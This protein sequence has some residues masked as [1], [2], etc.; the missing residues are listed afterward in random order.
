MHLFQG[1]KVALDH[2]QKSRNKFDVFMHISSA[3]LPFYHLQSKVGSFPLKPTYPV[4]AVF[5]SVS[6]TVILTVLS[7]SFHLLTDDGAYYC[8]RSVR[9]SRCS[10][11]WF[12]EE[13]N[14]L[15][16]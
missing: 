5:R 7:M 10:S 6:S 14:F 4:H 1:R 16:K 15:L 3:E 8:G 12:L 13:S 9:S 11:G 2:F